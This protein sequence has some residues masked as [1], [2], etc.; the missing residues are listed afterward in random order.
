M[1]VTTLPTV[2]SDELLALA[3]DTPPPCE[4]PEA[5][6]EAISCA[7]NNAANWMCVRSCCGSVVA[8]CDED[9]QK[10]QALMR[11]QGVTFICAS[12]GTYRVSGVH[13]LYS[14]I[15]PLER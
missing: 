7:G 10:R 15:W 9:F 6:G 14:V 11:Q 5:R 2:D 3:F 1:T 8:V 13:R 12:C 4:A